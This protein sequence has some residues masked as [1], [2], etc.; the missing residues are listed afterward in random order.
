MPDRIE[1]GTFMIAAAMTGGDVR[2]RNMR[3]DHLDALVFKLQDAGVEVFSR[4]DL[5]QVR[6][7]ETDPAGQHQD[8]P[9]SRL[10]R[11]TCRPSSWP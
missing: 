11:P 7:P 1:A 6:G 10:S 3:L 5:V 8:P 4:D 9:L 2:I